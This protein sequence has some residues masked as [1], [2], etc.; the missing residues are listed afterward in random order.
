[1]RQTLSTLHLEALRL[2]TIYEEHKDSEIDYM[3]RKAHIDLDRFLMENRETAM[4]LMVEGLQNAIDQQVA[5]AAKKRAA[6]PWYRRLRLRGG[7]V[8]ANHN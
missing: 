3:R 8:D 4:L 1:M 2:L 5:E 6:V 7:G